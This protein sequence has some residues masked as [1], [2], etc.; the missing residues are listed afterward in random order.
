[1]HRLYIL[2]EKSV[3]TVTIDQQVWGWSTQKYNVMGSK[4]SYQN[5]SYSSH[6]I[7]NSKK[8]INQFN[9]FRSSFSK[10]PIS[11]NEQVNFSN[12]WSYENLCKKKG[13]FAVVV[14]QVVGQLIANKLYTCI[15]WGQGRY[16]F[17]FHGHVHRVT[18]VS[19]YVV[20]TFALCKF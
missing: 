3:V 19:S 8:K 5:Y 20:D 13:A 18:S 16:T 17:F 15:L 10:S 14:L 7:L 11:S 1:M 9:Q 2:F 12:L 6:R 4:V